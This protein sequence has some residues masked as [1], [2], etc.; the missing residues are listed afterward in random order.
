MVGESFTIGV[1]ARRASV[2][3]QAVRYYERIGLLPK[4]RRT[5]SGYRRYTDE[6][7]AR[8]RVIGG[9]SSLGFSLAEIQELLALRADRG[10]SCSS[11]RARAEQKLSAIDQTIAE[12]H[13]L[14]TAVAQ[15]VDACDGDV[16]VERCA[17]LTSLAEPEARRTPRR[18]ARRLP[19]SLEA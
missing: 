7:L 16:A 1:L 6:D 13:R 18:R 17:I 10:G 14:R 3:V 19:S 9:A 12:L 15:L 8:L 4:P 2:S 11:I 5:P